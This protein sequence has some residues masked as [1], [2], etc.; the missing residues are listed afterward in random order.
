M[1][2][3]TTDWHLQIK[4]C[5][6][7]KG[8]IWLSLTRIIKLTEDILISISFL[9][10]I[11]I[12]FFIHINISFFIHIYLRAELEAVKKRGSD[13]AQLVLAIMQNTKQSLYCILSCICLII[14]TNTVLYSLQLLLRIW[15]WDIFHFEEE[16]TN[17]Q[18]TVT[19]TTTSSQNNTPKPHKCSFGKH[20]SCFS[21]N[22]IF[23]LLAEAVLIRN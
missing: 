8:L 16:K 9:I 18:A 20:T 3:Q 5:V 15:Y 13:T 12:S 1:G 2:P 14:A 22:I 19:T 11:S 21:I 4:S 6:S 17:K 7:W 10:H 23:F